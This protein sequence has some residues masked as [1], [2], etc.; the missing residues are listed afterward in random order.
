MET[1]QPIDY[2]QANFSELDFSGYDQNGYLEDDFI[3]IRFGYEVL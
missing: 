3:N 1:E 2:F